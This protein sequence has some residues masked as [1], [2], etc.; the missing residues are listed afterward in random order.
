MD[1][2]AN[3]SYILVNSVVSKLTVPYKLFTYEIHSIFWVFMQAE[4]LTVVDNLMYLDRTLRHLW[5]HRVCEELD[6]LFFIGGEL[7]GAFNNG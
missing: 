5:S 3:L 1:I 6:V 4:N 2:Q 7:V